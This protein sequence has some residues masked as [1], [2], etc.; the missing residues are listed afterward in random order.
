MKITTITKLQPE[1]KPE[2][3]TVWLDDNNNEIATFEQ[4]DSGKWQIKWSVTSFP[5]LIRLHLCPIE[6][7]PL[8]C[9]QTAIKKGQDAIRN[10]IKT[11][12]RQ[13]DKK[14]LCKFADYPFAVREQITDALDDELRIYGEVNIDEETGEATIQLPLSLDDDGTVT[15]DL[16]Q[17]ALA[18]FGLLLDWVIEHNLDDIGDQQKQTR[19]FKGS[20]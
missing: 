20:F 12:E 18:D 6:D 15:A 11:W 16:I 5:D 2:E 14:L 7:Y 1:P 3:T 13:T 17:H 10:L 8:Y 4:L 19:T 9:V